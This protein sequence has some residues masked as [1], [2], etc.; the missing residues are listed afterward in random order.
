MCTLF[1]PNLREI[2]DNLLTDVNP[3]DLDSLTAASEVLRKNLHN[4]I[5]L[6]TLSDKGIYL[7]SGETNI[8]QPAHIRNISDVSGAGDTVISV[9]T[10][11]LAAKAQLPQIAFL[12]NLAGGIVCEY[13]GVVSISPERLLEEALKLEQG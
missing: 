5:T 3:D 1:K 12:S 11:C 7:N 8:L 10:L 9:A 6:I 2:S 4:G 13:P